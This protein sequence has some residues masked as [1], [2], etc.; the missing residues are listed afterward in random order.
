MRFETFRILKFP[1]DVN[2]YL[3]SIIGTYNNNLFVEKINTLLQNTELQ[4]QL[5]SNARQ[6]IIRKFDW[7]SANSILIDLLTSVINKQK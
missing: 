6:M 1:T 4:T 3:K 7:A 5:G 2:N